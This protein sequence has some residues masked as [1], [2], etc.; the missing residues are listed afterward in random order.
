MC[1]DPESCISGVMGNCTGMMRLSG[2]VTEMEGRVQLEG[3]FMSLFLV[4]LDVCSF[5]REFCWC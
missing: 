1:S 4:W 5:S 2:M 3:L